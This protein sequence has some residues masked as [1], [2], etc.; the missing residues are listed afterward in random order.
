M[1][2]NW[3]FG[4]IVWR[5]WALSPHLKILAQRR[6]SRGKP[7]LLFLGALV[8]W[9]DLGRW[10]SLL[11]YLDRLVIA[12]HQFLTYTSSNLAKGRYWT[13]SASIFTFRTFHHFHFYRFSFFSTGFILRIKIFT[14]RVYAFLLSFKHLC[15]GRQPQFLNLIIN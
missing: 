14:K 12:F 9:A 4:Q 1:L 3:L 8:I 2:Q 13:Y 15:I 10:A 6:V 5:F 11:H 7:K